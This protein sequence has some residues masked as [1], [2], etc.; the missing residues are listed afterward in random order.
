MAQVIEVTVGRI[1]RAHG[2]K[3]EV[4]ID[5]R[6]DEP[7]RRFVPGAVLQLGSGPRT[8]EIATTRW[9]KGR[10]VVTLVGYPDRTAVEQLTGQ[11]LNVEVPVEERPSEPEEYFDRQ[12]V[13]LRVLDHAGDAAGTVAEV[14]HMPAQDLLRIDVDGEDRLV[15]FVIALVPVVDLEA[16]HVQLA[17]VGGLLEGDE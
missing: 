2:I 6:T 16:G 15:P 11:W 17:D 9:H 14:L 12:L 5:L 13:G 3:G 1:G 8:V 10:L 4:A 7:G